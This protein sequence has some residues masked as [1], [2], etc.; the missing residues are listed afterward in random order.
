MLVLP[1]L[2]DAAA[3]CRPLSM[4][5]VGDCIGCVSD[6][7]QV[8]AR[9]CSTAEPF[10]QILYCYAFLRVDSC[11]DS[12]LVTEAVTATVEQMQKRY[13]DANWWTNVLIDKAL[14]GSGR[15]TAPQRPRDD[16][17][18]MLR[19]PPGGRPAASE[20]DY[21]DAYGAGFGF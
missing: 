18:S 12:Q 20:R 10:N 17:A 15:F 6:W 21:G 7:E 2:I 8:N 5:H 4:E 9:E 19:D 1:L 11:D 14:R 13:I 3:V 16:A